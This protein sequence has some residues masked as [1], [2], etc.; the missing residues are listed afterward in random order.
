MHTI[1]QC[2]IPKNLLVM[3]FRNKI[4][5]TQKFAF[6][7]AE[8]LITLGIIGVVSAMTLPDLIDDYREKQTVTQL[9]K[10]YSQ[11]SQVY[12]L[13][14]EEN[15][16]VFTSNFDAASRD[17]LFNML[18]KHYN[19]IIECNSNSRPCYTKDYYKMLLGSDYSYGYGIFAGKAIKSFITADGVTFG[20][21][22]DGA[23][24]LEKIYVDLNGVKGPNRYGYDAFVFIINKNKI[25]PYKN[26]QYCNLTN[27]KNQ[28][29]PNGV[30]CTCWVISHENLDYQKCIKGKSKYCKINYAE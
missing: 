25:V 17:E 12:M 28:P 11:L 27:D 22:Y 30:G 10:V 15:G 14:M 1:S 19:K 21:G 18:K 20:I 29:V 9:K 6:T 2:F 4:G 8:V 26:A 24:Q 3:R 13:F 5:M 16:S 23:Y 7:L